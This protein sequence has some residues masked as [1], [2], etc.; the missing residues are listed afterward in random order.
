MKNRPFSKFMI[1]QDLESLLDGSED[2]G[3]LLQLQEET[4]DV[5]ESDDC[6]SVLKSCLDAGFSHLSEN[7]LPFF[8]PEEQG[9]TK[10]FSD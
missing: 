3:K 1:P 9:R 8:L 6:Y 5:L 2:D 4:M 10:H 7:I